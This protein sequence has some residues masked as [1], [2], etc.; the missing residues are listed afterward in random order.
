MSEASA[1]SG[2]LGRWIF[3]LSKLKG[4][5]IFSFC[6]LPRANIELLHGNVLNMY[7]VEFAL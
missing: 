7:T 6:S 3:H 1:R 5:P 4:T 2:I